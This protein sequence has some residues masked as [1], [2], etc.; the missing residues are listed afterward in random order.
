[1]TYDARQVVE[2]LRSGVPYRE[3]AKRVVFGR[4]KTLAHVDRLLESVEQAR[5]SKSPTYMVRANYGEGKTHLLQSVWG[6]AEERNWVVSQVSLSRET[7]LDR[8][9]QLYPKIMENTYV[10]GSRQAG[11]TRIIQDALDESHVLG[12]I[13]ALDL[14]PRVTAIVDNLM[15]RNEGLPELMAD[16]EG[17]VLPGTE[18]K[19]I[20]RKNF[21]RPLK[22]PRSSQ[23]DEVFHYLRLVDWMIHKA[24]YQG[25][26]ILF[27]EVELIGKLGRGARYRAYGNMGR[28]IAGSLPY[29][30]TVW[31][32]ASNFNS[33]VLLARNDREEAA[34]YLAARPKDEALAP[35]AELAMDALQESRMLDPLTKSQVQDLIGQ[36]YDLHQDA[37]GWQAPFSREDL[38]EQIRSLTP[39]QDTRVR[40]WVRLS[41]MALDIWY[42]YGA[43]PTIAVLNP[44]HDDDLD[45]D[46]DLSRPFTDAATDDEAPGDGTGDVTGGLASTPDEEEEGIAMRPMIIRTPPF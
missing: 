30:V 31:A 45:E 39:T 9:D 1:M 4:E 11:I 23:R 15:A 27:D 22:I 46:P 8:L 40:T 26:V 32:V 34:V 2:G 5:A 29:T 12:E 42:Q 38:Y 16:V 24:G 43:A 41:L 3:M 20:H 36:V 6:M 35:Y 37:Y 21:S 44:L 13:R 17:R 14:S 18:L 25:W 19:Q 33:D 10:P 7:P 28:M